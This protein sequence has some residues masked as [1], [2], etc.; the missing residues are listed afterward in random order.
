MT[1]IFFNTN[2]T[3]NKTIRIRENEMQPYLPPS[4]RNFTPQYMAFSTWVDHL[5]FGYDI[6]A[7]VR[8][9]L[10]VELGTQHGT[11][12]FC[13]CQSMAENNIDGL[14]YAV[15][16]W[17]GDEH[18][19][20]YDNTIFETVQQH[21]RKNHASISYLMRMLFNDALN[22]FS[23]ESIDL[24]HI[25]GLH[26]YEAVSE[27]FN[28][29]YPKVKPGG[30]ILFHDIQARMMDFGA[31]KFWEE[32]APQYNSFT[33]KQGFGLGV[34]RKAGG[35]E[36]THPLLKM[37]FEGDA[38]THEALRAFYAHA[39]K[40]HE[41]KRKVARQERHQQQKKQQQLDNAEKL[42]PSHQQPQ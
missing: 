7:A 24:V 32:I 12:F 42:S 19:G 14:C 8:P 21:A 10:L 17:A 4:L 5:P 35:A 11:S 15:D 33:F 16:T 6:V 26:T 34:L 37:L 36:L 30:V 3:I 38:G 29:W 23:D 40:F 31:W 18:T 13:F 39:S 27:D 28:N 22:H 20:E 1:S 41:L 2:L 25:D 9:Q